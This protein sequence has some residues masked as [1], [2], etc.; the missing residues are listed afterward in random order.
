M[1]QQTQVDRVIPKY[2]EFIKRF[3]TVSNL[4]KASSADVLRMWKGLGYNRRAL[5]LK[6]SA[7]QI[8]RYHKAILP[9]TDKE[10]TQLPGVGT[11]TARAVCIFA[12]GQD[13]AAVDTNIRKII[14]HEFFNDY[15]QN[16]K[17]I[18]GIALLLVPKGKSWEW[19]Q[20]LMDYGASELR[21]MKYEGIRKKKSVPF[22]RSDRFVRGIIIDELRIRSREISVLIHMVSKQYGKEIAAVRR[23][24]LKLEDE[25]LLRIKR[26]RVSLPS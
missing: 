21:K 18:E 7:E 3:P 5:Y 14:V 11:Y 22:K 1:L 25:G 26:N 24:L 10:L 12:Y 16:Q 19:H 9:R 8:V 23:I 13:I 4:A 20:A 15:E 17:I 2:D 6:R